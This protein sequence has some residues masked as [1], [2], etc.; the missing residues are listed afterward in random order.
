MFLC[1]KKGLRN[2]QLHT[3]TCQSTL[4]TNT[5]QKT[6][7]CTDVYTCADRFFSTLDRMYAQKCV[8][9]TVCLHMRMYV[10]MDV[11][12]YVRKYIT[13]MYVSESI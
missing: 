12:K 2:T 4:K 7:I 9:K 6:S 1:I 8:Y 3:S 13:D 5:H 11:C 10:R